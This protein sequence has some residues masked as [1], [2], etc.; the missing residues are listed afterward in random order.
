MGDKYDGYKAIIDAPNPTP[1][2]IEAAGKFALR[3]LDHWTK[4][5]QSA[6]KLAEETHKPEPWRQIENFKQQV[7]DFATKATDLAKQ[8]EKRK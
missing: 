1:R 8:Y 5:E 2:N 3:L 7:E 6:Q 4:W